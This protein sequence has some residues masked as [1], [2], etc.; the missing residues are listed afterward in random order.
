MLFYYRAILYRYGIFLLTLIIDLSVVIINIKL[1]IFKKMYISWS[2]SRCHLY[3]VV[4]H[5]IYE[6][7]IHNNK[8]L[9]ANFL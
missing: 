2:T 7:L 6:K 5:D 1:F 3:L 8:L 4:D 9:F